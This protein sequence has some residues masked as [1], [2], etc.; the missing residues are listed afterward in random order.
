MTTEAGVTARLAASAA[1]PDYEALYRLE[2]PRVFNY[3]WYRTGDKALADD[4]TSQT[5]ERAWR[6]RH[7]YRRDLAAFSTWLFTIARCVAA[8]HYRGRRTHVALDQIAGLAAP[9]DT[10]LTAQQRIDFTRLLH[11]LKDLPVRQQEL[12]AL[13]YGAG[14]TQREI[15]SLMRLSESNVGVI[16]F[17]V[18]RDLRAK[19]EA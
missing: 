18:L 6:K 16:L 8:D 9:D 12:V 13:R 2:L 5:F 7:H 10:E 4:L 11:L 14:L 3:F 19:W 1:E 17:R 15:A